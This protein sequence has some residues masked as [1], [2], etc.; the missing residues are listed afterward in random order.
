M[1]TKL[2]SVQ[3][4]IFREK[5]KTLLQQKHL[6]LKGVIPKS[7]RGIAV[8]SPWIRKLSCIRKNIQKMHFE[9]FFQIFLFFLQ[10]FS[11]ILI[12]IDV[13]LIYQCLKKLTTPGLL[14]IKSI[15][16]EINVMTSQMLSMTSLKTIITWLR[17]CCRCG[18]MTE[19][20][21]FHYISMRKDIITSCL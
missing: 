15:F 10:S 18:H 6:L 7:L 11:V 20:S 3:F 9:T 19:V 1:L 12:D 21:Y 8:F 2:S 4:N 5:E 17:F 16:K 13:W 14:E